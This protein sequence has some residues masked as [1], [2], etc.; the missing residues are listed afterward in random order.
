M[1]NWQ[2]ETINHQQN[3]ERYEN[4]ESV[5]TAGCQQY[6]ALC[7]IS[8]KW[9][10]ISMDLLLWRPIGQAF[11]YWSTARPHSSQHLSK[12]RPV[13]KVLLEIFV[14]N[15]I[16][17]CSVMLIIIVITIWNGHLLQCSFWSWIVLVPGIFCASTWI[18]G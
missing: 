10:I 17:F 7:L 4:E 14:W 9:D 13:Q 15:T 11:I 12:W 8:T 6:S 2:S 3:H 5:Q 1:C 18:L 16:L